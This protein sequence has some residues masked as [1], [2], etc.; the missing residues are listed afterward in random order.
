MKKLNINW[1]ELLPDIIIFSV[2]LIASVIYFFPA[3]Q[4][5]VVPGV[6]R[7]NA[8]S[9]RM[10]S[11][12]YF[13][14]TGENAYWTNSMFSGMPTY[15]IGGYEYI[16]RVLLRPFYYICLLGGDNVFFLMLFYLIV[17]YCL[18]RSFNI[19]KWTS[20]AG[21]FAT[22]LSS[23]FFVIIA[24]SHNAKAL[25]I[26]W[27]SLALVGFLLV[28]RKKYFVGALS[29]MLFVPI[30]LFRH[31]QM[32]YYICMLIGV[33]FFAELYQ[34]LREKRY[35]DFGISTAIFAAAFLVGMGIGSANVFSNQEYASQ[36]MRG[37]HSD[38]VKEKDATNKVQNGLDL[39]YA[40][41]WSYGIDETMTFLIP[42]FMGRAS[43][44][45]VGT[46]S[47]LYK[48]L[49]AAGV[50]ANSARQFTE[51]APV[52]RG[53]KPFTMGPVY[54]GAIVCFLFLLGLLIVSGPYKWALLVATLFSVL[55]SWGRHFMP[56]TEFFFNYFPMYNK[57]RAVESILI[58]AEITMPLLAFLAVNELIQGKKDKKKL[59]TSVY[60]SAGITAG[61]CLFF[62]LFGKSVV[63]FTSAY[64]SNLQ[65]QLP[66]FAYQA[67]L[68]QRAQMLTADAWRSL[69]FIVLAAVL[70]WFYIRK[71][72]KS[73]YFS[74]A[75][76]AL[77][78]ADLWPVNKRYCNDDIF[79]T[80][81][82]RDKVFNIQ[83][84]EKQI[85]Q[86]DGY[87]RVFNLT[88][89]PF[90]DARTSYRL[91]SIG[92]YHA[93]KLRR[94]QD[95]IDEH[96]SKM[97]WNVIN[98]LNTKYIITAGQDGIATPHLNPDAMGNAWFV[99][100]LL[101]VDNANEESD[102]LNYLD[103]HTT[104]VLDKEF[105]SFVTAI[106]TEHDPT[107]R[108]VLTGHTPNSVEFQTENQIEKTLVLSEIYY[109]FG[110]KATIDDE[111]VEH[112]RVNYM[113]RALNVP[114]GKHHIVFHFDP[115]SIRKGNML[116]LACIIVFY[117]TAAAGIVYAVLRYRKRKIS[118][119]N[120]D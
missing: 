47:V 13:N 85:L 113:L 87:Y 8:Y 34:H 12:S 18:L 7:I 21:A 11:W 26:T 69:A 5:K 45:N 16:D 82:Q 30:G 97:N 15:M 67:I 117:L 17:F 1:K 35:K 110:W 52:Y 107:A 99:D 100:S 88:S 53:D 65:R 33:L 28:Y 73:I 27:M 76:A 6:D 81:K 42:D 71:S 101:V 102:A 41:A 95:L 104:A 40:T 44:T 32:G 89:D 2:F 116:S 4:G 118:A 112:F 80:V 59:L 93:A 84:Y 38:L 19:E 3:L 36:T 54:M 50:P 86:D 10:E 20:M 66:D 58:V 68:H 51:H 103:L 109:P 83:P 14:E 120:A 49:V 22:A 72:F 55:L 98:M 24:A 108:V 90:N 96:L 79:V 63:D 56:F 77:V 43:G 105:A 94:Y 25:A 115:D 37:G 106:A 64:D 23:Y 119:T 29:L 70:V 92:G 74:L 75:L 57:F 111:P 62:A 46:K 60:I 39:D 114:A 91:H 61:V 78:V 31:P 48:E 9:G